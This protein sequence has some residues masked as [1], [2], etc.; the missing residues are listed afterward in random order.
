MDGGRRVVLRA[1]SEDSED[2]VIKPLASS[3]AFEVSSDG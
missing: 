3:Q 2:M 1:E